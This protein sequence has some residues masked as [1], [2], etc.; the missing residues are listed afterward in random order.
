MLSLRASCTNE[1]SVQLPARGGAASLSIR[2]ERTEN[3][4]SNTLVDGNEDTY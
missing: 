1:V 4:V 3:D 2:L